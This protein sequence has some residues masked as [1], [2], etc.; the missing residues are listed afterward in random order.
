MD[1]DE[2]VNQQREIAIA[3]T[4]DVQRVMRVDADIMEAVRDMVAT[5][6]D[7]LARNPRLAFEARVVPSAAAPSEHLVRE[8]ELEGGQV[9]VVVGARLE[10]VKEEK[11]LIRDTIKRLLGG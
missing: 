10:L 3:M 9:D 4:K 7:E 11:G 2:F 6:R 1:P 8:D 5:A